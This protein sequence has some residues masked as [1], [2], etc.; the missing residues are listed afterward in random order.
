M[1]MNVVNRLICVT[2]LVVSFFCSATNVDKTLVESIETQLTLM[3]KMWV[4]VPKNIESIAGGIQGQLKDCSQYDS[5]KASLLCLNANSYY[6]E[7]VQAVSKNSSQDVIEQAYSNYMEATQEAISVISTL[8]T[9][10]Y[11]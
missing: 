5:E 10:N 11:K 4:E 6:R 9:L 8:N 3:Q 7:Y 1:S 2:L